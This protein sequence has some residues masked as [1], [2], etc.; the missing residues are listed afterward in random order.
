MLSQDVKS[1]T[2]DMLKEITMAKNL[3]VKGILE[4]HCNG[5]SIEYCIIPV[6]AV[7]L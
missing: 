2:A 1:K 5:K 3:N 7:L 4:K 6:R